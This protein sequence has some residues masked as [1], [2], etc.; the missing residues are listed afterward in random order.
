[1]LKELRAVRVTHSSIKPPN[2]RTKTN[3]N[4]NKQYMPLVSGVV[5]PVAR[6]C[7][8]L[9]LGEQ[10]TWKTEDLLAGKATKEQY[11]VFYAALLIAAHSL[12]FYFWGI[13]Y[14]VIHAVVPLE[15]LAKW[16]YQGS[17]LADKTLIIEA[18]LYTGAFHVVISIVM[19]VYVAPWAAD[20][21]FVA[22]FG[23]DLV[24]TTPSFLVAFPVILIYGFLATTAFFFGH[25]LLHMKSPVN[26][27]AAIH[28]Q[29]HRFYV[30]CSWA[31]E[32]AHPV[33]LVLGNIIPVIAGPI[34]F[35]LLLAFGPASVTA[36]AGDALRAGLHPA[37]WWVWMTLAIT[38]TNLGHSGMWYPS[39]AHVAGYHDFHHSA[40]SGN[41]G[42]NS[43]L[44]N[45]F[46]TNA[47]WKRHLVSRSAVEK[48]QQE[49][50]TPSQSPAR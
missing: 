50:R 38:Q 14:T 17:K 23:K 33:E 19:G 25:W 26:L 15:T 44:D 18:V 30:S 45:F 20:S 34:V 10:N 35:W 9:V 24:E 43:M 31:C 3:N 36:V 1:V 4:N 48:W 42:T 39:I 21:G 12:T 5:E 2:E 40:N 47:A 6:F 13:F 37:V 29:H 49:V 27:Y 28:K 41:Y 32:Y 22:A 7:A 16:R 11:A 46:G 8:G